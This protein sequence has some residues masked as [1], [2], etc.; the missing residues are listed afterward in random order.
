MID[1]ELF[2]YGVDATKYMIVNG[3]LND[4]DNDE[5]LSLC[6]YI[7]EVMRECTK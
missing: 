4:K 3:F 7:L 5:K 2:L 1:R 6:E